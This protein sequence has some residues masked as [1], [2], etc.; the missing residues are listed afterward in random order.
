M[1]VVI[2]STEVREVAMDPDQLEIGSGMGTGKSCSLNLQVP[3][4]AMRRQHRTATTLWGR[5]SGRGMPVN[6]GFGTHPGFGSFPPPMDQRRTTLNI[7]YEYNKTGPTS[8]T[9]LDVALA[10]TYRRKYTVLT[11]FSYRHRLW[12]ACKVNRKKH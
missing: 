6:P 10:H 5:C 4:G 8:L 2:V 1:G 9:F 3:Q 12:S 7:E 11:A